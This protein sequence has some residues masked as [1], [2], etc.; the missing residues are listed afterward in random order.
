MVQLCLGRCFPCL[1]LCMMS[2]STVVLSR[3]QQDS[4]LG[5][6]LVLGDFMGS[7]LLLSGQW[8]FGIK[9]AATL[10]SDP[11]VSKV[12]FLLAIKPPFCT[13]LLSLIECVCV[14]LCLG[15]EPLDFYSIFFSFSA[16]FLIGIS[17]K[18]WNT[19]T[20]GHDSKLAFDLGKLPCDKFAI[21]T[22]NENAVKIALFVTASY[23]VAM[24]L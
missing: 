9:E 3:V 18:Y 5:V 21:L 4:G 10:P 11:L 6:P 1:L 12:V 22:I 14:V 19:Y 17:I 8:F 20:T 2:H 15:V 16:S 23:V 13:A 7:L 24:S